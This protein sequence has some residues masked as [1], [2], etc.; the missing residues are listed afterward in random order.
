MASKNKSYVLC[1]ANGNYYGKF[2]ILSINEKQSAFIDGSGFLMQSFEL[3]LLRDF[4][5]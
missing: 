4:D 1:S 5:E 2:A 3:N